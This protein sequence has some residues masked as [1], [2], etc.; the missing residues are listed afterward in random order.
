MLVA[1]PARFELTTSAF[2]GQRCP[3]RTIIFTYRPSRSCTH[4]RAVYRSAFWLNR[5]TFDLGTLGFEA[6]LPEATGR[7]ACHPG[8]LLKIYAYGCINEIA[9]SRR[10]ERRRS[11]TSS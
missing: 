7:P 2:G 1:D 3:F 5:T 9:A 11:A 8:V 6:V 10:L 4:S